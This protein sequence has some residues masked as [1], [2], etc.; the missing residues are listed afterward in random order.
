MHPSG[1]EERVNEVFDEEPGFWRIIL[2]KP[3]RRTKGVAFD[4]VPMELLPRIDGIDRVIHEH[5]AFSPGSVGEVERPWYLHPHQEDNLIVLAGVRSVDIYSAAAGRM[6]HFVVEPSRVW[7]NGRLVC[8][9]PAMLVWPVNVYHRIVSGE[10]GSASL[11]FAVRHEGFDVHTN[12]SV[13]DL[14]PATGVS[15]VLREGRLDQMTG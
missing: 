9:H 15:R 6:E 1:R 2:L 14:D 12:F 4:I 8:D 10:N 13:Y 7:H 3:F 11:N 5:G